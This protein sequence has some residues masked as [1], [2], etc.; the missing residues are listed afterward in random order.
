MVELIQQAV[1]ASGVS[2]NEVARRAGLDSGQ[3]SRFMT[4]R[5]DLTLS[6]ASRLCDA[7]GLRLVGGPP[8]SRKP[9]GRPNK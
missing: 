2:Y 5:R 7:L 1:R 9:R 6:A 8:E 4:G 3:V